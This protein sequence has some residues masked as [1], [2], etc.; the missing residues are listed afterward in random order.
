MNETSPQSF[1]LSLF[2]PSLSDDLLLNL[3]AAKR[4]YRESYKLAFMVEGIVR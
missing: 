4:S 3:V 1:Q 2:P